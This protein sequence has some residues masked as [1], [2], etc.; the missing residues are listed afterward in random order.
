RVNQAMRRVGLIAVLSIACT[1]SAPPESP[2]AIASTPAPVEPDP[3]PPRRTQ[4]TNET[5]TATIDPPRPTASNDPQCARALA[6]YVAG[7]DA[8]AAGQPDAARKQ[9]LILVRDFP[10]CP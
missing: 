1:S 7:A 5:T 2:P 10:A 8:M 4:D 6:L 9:W 3:H